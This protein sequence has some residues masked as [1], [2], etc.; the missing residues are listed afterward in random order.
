MKKEDIDILL[1]KYF[2][3]KT[4]LEEENELK[5]FFSS[6]EIPD[7]WKVYDGLFG[8]F[9]K[10]A[11]V[12]MN[13]KKMR[14]VPRENRKRVFNFVFYPAVAVAVSLFVFVFYHDFDNSYVKINGKK[15]RQPEFIEQYTSVKLKKVNYL[16]SGSLNPLENLHKAKEAVERGNASFESVK[17]TIYN[18]YDRSEERRVGKECRSRWSPY[19]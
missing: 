17:E 4:T 11:D 3:A 7:E 1:E 13:P 14:F 19:H 10:E 9:V 8:A 6:E 5:R 12:K 18:I 2:Q 15:I 16:L